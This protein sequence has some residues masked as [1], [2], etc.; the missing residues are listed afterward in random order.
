MFNQSIKNY[1]VVTFVFE[2]SLKTETDAIPSTQCVKF[3]YI[4]LKSL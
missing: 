1:Y 4:Q 2:A 3:Q